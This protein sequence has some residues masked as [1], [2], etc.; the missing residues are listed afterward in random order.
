MANIT[1]KRVETLVATAIKSS[2]DHYKILHEAVVIAI[3]FAAQVGR[4]EPL[5]K[6]FNGISQADRESLRLY[7]VNLAASDFG[8]VIVTD[9]GKERRFDFLNYDKEAKAFTIAKANGERGEAI[10][11]CRDAVSKADEKELLSIS[12]EAP[13][14][15]DAD[16]QNNAFDLWGAIANLIQRAAREGWSKTDL[17]ALNRMIPDAEKRVDVEKAANAAK[18]QL[19]K[20]EKRVKDMRERLEKQEAKAKELAEKVFDSDEKTEPA[21]EPVSQAA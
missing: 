2:K 11:A 8:A 12:M 9:E 16:R 21:S 10:K 14:R 3:Q 15:D 6:L 5:S 1:Q 19:E 18:A 4:T 20:A 13:N 17:N 7:R